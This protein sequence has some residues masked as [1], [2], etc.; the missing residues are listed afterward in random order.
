M[1]SDHDVPSDHDIVK[2]HSW[3]TQVA[4]HVSDQGNQHNSGPHQ[5]QIFD[6]PAAPRLAFWAKN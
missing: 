3:A 5:D 4:K 1:P 6:N 2:G